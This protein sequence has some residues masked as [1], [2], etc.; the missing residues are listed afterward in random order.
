MFSKGYRQKRFSRGR[1]SEDTNPVLVAAVTSDGW[2]GEAIFPSCLAGFPFTRSVRPVGGADEG[3]VW[4]A[5]VD[6]VGKPFAAR[7]VSS[8][9]DNM[10]CDRIV[11]TYGNRGRS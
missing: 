11:V 1:K 4:D 10:V 7:D 8:G 6:Y 9:V 2:C 5:R 3:P